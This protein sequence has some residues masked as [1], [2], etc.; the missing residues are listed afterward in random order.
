MKSSWWR[1]TSHQKQKRKKNHNCLGAMTSLVTRQGVFSGVV[2]AVWRGL[3]L[4]L[5]GHQHVQYQGDSFLDQPPISK[6]ILSTTIPSDLEP[7][8][9]SHTVGLHSLQSIYNLCCSHCEEQHVVYRGLGHGCRCLRL[10]PICTLGAKQIPDAPPMLSVCLCG[11]DE[12][13]YTQSVIVLWLWGV[14]SS[15]VA[16]PRA[17]HTRNPKSNGAAT[18]EVASHH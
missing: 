18:C 13:T 5:H 16:G 2:F 11:N 9:P 3:H 17:T 1:S 8:L 15:A 7:W 4:H 6:M 14:A 12:S 10:K